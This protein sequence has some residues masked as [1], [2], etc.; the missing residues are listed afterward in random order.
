MTT[1]LLTGDS[2]SFRERSPGA[3]WHPAVTPGCVHTDLLRN[4]LIPDPFWGRNEL[5]LQWIEERDWE[6]RLRFEA[7]EALLLEEAVELAADGVDTFAT[8]FLNGRE[9]GRADNMFA[10]WRWD[11]KAR[12]R[13]GPNELRIVFG[14][15]MKYIRANNHR[16]AVPW[17]FN[18]PVGGCVLARKQQSQFGWDWGPRFVTCGVWREI[19]LEGWS[20]NRFAHVEISQHHRAPRKG[21][22]GAGGRAVALRLR[23]EMRR[24]ARRLAYEAVVT[25][26]G[27]E[28]AAAG[29]SAL[30]AGAFEIT[31][32]DAELWWPSGL[33][34]Q[35]LHEVTVR[36]LDRDGRVVDA[37]TRRV[38]LRT[39]EL[40]REPDEWGESFK[41]VVNGTPVF[42]KGAN[43][44]PADSFVAGLDRGRYARD[45]RA[46][47]AA[48]FNCLRVWG[49]GIY[50]SEDFY[51][52]CDELGLLVWQDFMFACTLYPSDRAFLKSVEAE[53]RHQVRRLHHRACLA[54][55]CG[56]NEL[57]M[58]NGPRLRGKL[59]RGYE[60]L[61]HKLLPEAVRAH[62]AGTAYWP[63][64]PWRGDWRHGTGREAGEQRGDTHYWDVWHARHPAR[65]YEKW[66][67]RFVSEFGM[68]SFCTPKTQATYCPP[69]DANVFGPS[70][71][72]HQKNRAGNQI[73]LDYV[74]RRYRFPKNQ[75]ALGYL[76]QLNQAYA[77][78][79]AVEHYR[80]LMPRCMGALYWQLN[81]CWPV[82]SW[83]SI[84]YTGEWK[85]LHHA[86]RR[87]YASAAV[88]A[89]IIGDEA[90]ITGNYRRSTV[91][92]VDLYTVY[93]GPGKKD[94]TLAWEIFHI[95]GRVLAGGR[96][97][98][99]LRNGESQRRRSL[100]PRKL[101]A[102]H[103]RDNLV[104]RIALEVGGA[105]VGEDSVFL[106]PPRFIALRRGETRVTVKRGADARHFA[107]TFVSREFQHRFHFDLDGFA[108]ASSD[109][110]FELFP[111]RA[112]TV[113]VTLDRPATAAGV[114]AALRFGSL[115]DS[116]E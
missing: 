73:I 105:C 33:G 4:K 106:V 30:K 72:N 58:T 86:A 64:S 65:D 48:N 61:F 76:S 53:A 87:F 114:R 9:I 55:W 52:L 100:D 14:S 17:E 110:Y 32:P 51:D 2:W 24:P 43:W 7:D 63:T 84:E 111:G 103:G 13:P 40:V 46:A 96:R 85:A 18:D 97:K 82:A 21:G 36:A 44:I 102:A 22:G 98:V 74:S 92:R 77:M 95:D 90:T 109:N 35:P 54:L 94:A 39:L 23:P 83:S 1:Q 41:F 29:P 78:Q 68:Q 26:R 75:A 91:E 5:D 3:Q 47:A 80:R 10:A 99:T 115:V 79:I 37:W 89:H 50:E 116:Y 15:A 34:A 6:Y 42:I 25:L 59:K 107:L 11:V 38:G 93:D 27:S 28:V 66:K 81:D 8:F 69:D 20:G 56:N 31:V 113:E 57:V 101:M 67:F 71:E 112:K 62:G 49:G 60:E 88:S 104:L 19:R 12:L 16:F 45:V 108:H 70:N